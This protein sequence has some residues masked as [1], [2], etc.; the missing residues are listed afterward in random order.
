M[1][2]ELL[3]TY[4]ALR[5]KIHFILNYSYRLVSI[6]I[7]TSLEATH[8]HLNGLCKIK[9]FSMQ[10]STKTNA[11][12]YEWRLQVISKCKIKICSISISFR[13]YHLFSS[14]HLYE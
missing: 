12:T 14:P 11:I 9:V 3:I 5:L 6:F 10:S 2:H 7:C 8:I 1:Y 13:Q 4:E